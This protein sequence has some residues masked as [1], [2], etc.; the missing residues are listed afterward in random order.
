MDSCE[1]DRG[2]LALRAYF[3]W[4]DRFE[5]RLEEMKEREEE[6][7]RIREERKV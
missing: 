2:D 1:A 3:A 5:K 6:T 7:V 4:Y